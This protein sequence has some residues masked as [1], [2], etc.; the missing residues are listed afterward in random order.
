MAL[1]LT[2]TDVSGFIGLAGTVIA[3]A[4]ALVAAI[5]FSV[6]TPES[7]WIAVI[8]WLAGL[9]LS[10][11]NSFTGNWT[12]LL[13]ALISL[14]VALALTVAI[15]VLRNMPTTRSTGASRPS[16]LRRKRARTNA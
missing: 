9:L 7:G 11:C 12:L 10:L 1:W 4:S 2:L 3:L 14:P 6:G 16:S 15:A 13:F 5:A 8:G